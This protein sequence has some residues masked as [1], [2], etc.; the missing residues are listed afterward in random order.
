MF[1]LKKANENID[2]LIEWIEEQTALEKQ[3][4][5]FDPDVDIEEEIDLS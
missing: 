4:P 1:D 5:S 2:N 3:Y